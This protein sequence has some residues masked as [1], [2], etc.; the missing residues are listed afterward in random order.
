MLS[1]PYGVD[2]LLLQGWPDPTHDCA[3]CASALATAAKQLT[4]NT[5]PMYES[6]H[7]PHLQNCLMQVLHSALNLLALHISGQTSRPHEPE[8]VAALSVSGPDLLEHLQLA[9][10]EL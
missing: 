10:R 1:S 3:Y 8:R 7:S 6:L 2:V 9:R 5:P 4:P